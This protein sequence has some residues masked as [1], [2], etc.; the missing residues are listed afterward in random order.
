M[1]PFCFL[2]MAA[3]LFILTLKPRSELFKKKLYR[4]DW[5]IHHDYHRVTGRSDLGRH[6]G[7]MEQLEDDCAGCRWYH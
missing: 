7:A 2:A 1:F 3:I 6:S 5:F 4:V